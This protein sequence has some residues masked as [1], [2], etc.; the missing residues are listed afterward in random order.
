KA[1][2]FSFEKLGAVDVFLGPEMKSTGEVL[3]VDME[4]PVALYKAIIG[5]GAVTPER[6][7][8]LATIADKDM[9]EAKDSLAACHAAGYSFVATEG[10]AQLLSEIGVPVT[11]VHKIGDGHPNVVEVIKEGKVDL[12][13]NTPTRGKIPKRNGFQMR[14]AAVEFQVPVITALDSGKALL[15]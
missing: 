13:F 3:G 4:Y 2:V 6:G 10:T 5:S 9:E 8:M 7:T 15:E 12:L 14:R 1:P 11:E